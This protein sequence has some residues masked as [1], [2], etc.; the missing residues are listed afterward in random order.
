MDVNDTILPPL[1]VRD[2]NADGS[3]LNS[4]VKD[5]SRGPEKEPGI[6]SADQVTS[7][8]IRQE[9]HHLISQFLLNS[10]TP[11]IP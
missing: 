1:S 5:A 6:G 10:M 2:S 4:R 7:L 11:T 8:G 9:H 3:L